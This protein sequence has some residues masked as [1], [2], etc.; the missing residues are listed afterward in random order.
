MTGMETASMMPSI[1]SG[2]LIRDTPPCARMSAG[3]RS[4]AMTATAP[5][6]S[7][8]FAC[9][10]GDHV[11]D[12]AALEHLGHAALDA[13]GA[14]D[15][16]SDSLAGCSDTVDHSSTRMRARYVHATRASGPHRRPISRGGLRRALAG[17]TAPAVAGACRA[18][19]QAGR[20]SRRTRARVAPASRN[21]RPAGGCAQRPRVADRVVVDLRGP[22]RPRRLGRDHLPHRSPAPARVRLG[23]ARSARVRSLSAASPLVLGG[24]RARPGG[25]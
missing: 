25:R 3:T 20:R 1:M 7:A 12:H 9:S 2:S 22:A 15:R 19:R 10:G 16:R 13:G 17:W 11:H 23:T 4:S 24:R 6:S 8:I 21:R 18:R 14:G 5:A